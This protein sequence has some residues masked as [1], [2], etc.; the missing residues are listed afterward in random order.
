MTVDL[1]KVGVH[2]L[3]KI[4]GDDFG[5]PIYRVPKNPIRRDRVEGVYTPDIVTR[6]G[7]KPPAHV[8]IDYINTPESFYRVLGKV[9]WFAQ[10]LPLDD[11]GRP[12][13]GSCPAEIIMVLNDEIADVKPDLGHLHLMARSNLPVQVMSMRYFQSWMEWRVKVQLRQ[14]LKKLE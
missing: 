14:D 6:V 7:V 9:Y 13:P 10:C 5:L 2:A 1:H 12:T 11:E 4:V 8:W 3:K